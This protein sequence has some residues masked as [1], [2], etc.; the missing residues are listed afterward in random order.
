MNSLADEKSPYL[1][2]HAH[3]PVDWLPWGEAAFQKA[4]DEDKPIFLSIGYSTCHWCHVMERES[5]E[6][7]A[8]AQVMNAHFVNVKVDREERPD[9]DKLYMTFVQATTGQGGWPLSL[10]LTPDLKPF[11]GGTYFPPQNAYGRIGF[12]ELLERIAAAW[13]NDR[14]KV[15]ESSESV[16]Q[17]LERYAGL[18]AGS[19][20]EAADWEKISGLCLAH[21]QSVF[22][23]RYGGFGPA[24]K[25]PRPVAHDFL[26]RYFLESNDRVAFQMSR[27]TLVAMADG[28]MN[29]QLGGGFHRY[30]V[31]SQWIVSHFEKMLYDQAQLAISYLE[32]FQLTREE[33]F[34]D[35]ARSI[36]D[37]VLR[38]LTHESGGFF[39][40]EDADS[41]PHENADHKTEGAFYLW[42][43]NE[44]EAVLGSEAAAVFCEYYGVQPG[45][46]APDEGD[47]HGEFKNQNI[48]YRAQTTTDAA[49]LGVLQ[50]AREKLFA[51]RENRPRPHRDEKI[52]V[53][54]NGLMISALA[55]AAGVL[56]EPKYLQAARRA[57]EFIRRELW[58][59]NEQ[60]LRRHFKDGAANVSG[61][62]EDYAFLSRALLDL[63][64]AD[65][66]ISDLQWAQE[67]NEVLLENF[68][69]EENGGLYS[70]APD[71][72]I[73]LRFKEDYDGAEPSPNSVAAENCVRLHQLL[74]EERYREKA[75]VIFAAF[76]GR[77][78]DAAPAMPLLLAARLSFDAPPQHAVIVGEKDAG[79]TQQL[80]LAARETFSP[81]QTLILLD[82]NAREFW[83]VRQPFLREMKML[84]GKAT[85][86]ICRDF[87]CRKPVTSADELRAQMVK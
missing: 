11:F 39:A 17:A 46:N 12:P 67:L 57:G 40:G 15:L 45:G 77:L 25:F 3:N 61:F 29:D 84:N 83:N 70:S 87:A 66:Q 71:E 53:A 54:W 50:S 32:M 58:N 2:Q 69:D 8:I 65:F 6:N 44:I 60:A 55:R 51:A 33:F 24:P 18:H 31:D 19:T 38:D 36:C 72:N 74:D 43:Q 48:L 86:Y 73:L 4:R 63:Y 42:T 78:R 75:A 14:A 23:S 82:E 80:L 81:H 56:A 7:E 85:V 64:E 13:Q 22:D 26:H 68:W 59:E 10:F 5:F 27:K 47:P 49:T 62:A 16:L 79:D 35:T 20:P 21:F 34:A 37:Y 76:A 28:G 9:V 30:A 41:L 1:L 52:I